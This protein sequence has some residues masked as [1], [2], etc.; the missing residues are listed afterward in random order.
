MSRVLQH[1]QLWEGQARRVDIHSASLL[2][3]V[4]PVKSY[5]QAVSQL[6][7]DGGNLKYKSV[8]NLQTK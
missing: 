4:H 1:P 6:V 7:T 5:P 8:F 3:F 2:I